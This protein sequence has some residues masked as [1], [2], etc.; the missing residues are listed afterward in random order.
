MVDICN[1]DDSFIHTFA[2]LDSGKRKE[3]WNVTR[4]NQNF[5]PSQKH[6]YAVRESR[7][8]YN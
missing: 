3:I 8:P 4:E 2:Y 6:F 7:M 5:S 1:L